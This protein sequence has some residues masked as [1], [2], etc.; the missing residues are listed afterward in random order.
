MAELNRQ[1]RLARR[2]AGAIAPGDLEFASG[3]LPHIG[4]GQALV[5]N[6]FLSLDP[7]NRIWMSDRDQYLPPVE[8]GAVMRGG[9]IGVVTQSQEPTLPVGSIVAPGLSGWQEYDVA[10]AGIARVLPQIPGVPVTAYMS[11]LGLTGW[12]AYFGLLDIGQ[13]KPG[14]TLVVSAAAGAVGSIVG[15]IGK[16]KG[17]RVVGIAGS[18]D[19]CRWITEDLGFDA[20]INYKTEDVGAALDRHCPNGIDINFENVGGPIMDAV[21]A[22]MNNF[23]RMPLCGMISTY[24]AEDAPGPANFPLILMKRI[25]VQ[26]FIV[27][28]YF[29]RLGEAIQDLAQWVLSGQIKYK[30]HIEHGLENAADAVNRLFTGEHDGKLLVQIADLPEGVQ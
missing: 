18:A 25:K 20:A 23:S 11:A 30:V 28:D 26:G 5:K 14:D 21:L 9:T 2:P 15:Q 7:T 4:P 8:I 24:N 12:T 6:L 22:R 1:W 17:C 27:I 29:P 10:T 16:L 19:K 13:P 3:P